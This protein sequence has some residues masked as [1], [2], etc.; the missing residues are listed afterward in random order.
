MPT[1]S[2][3]KPSR[4]T[5]S[6]VPVKIA[7]HRSCPLPRRSCGGRN[8]APLPVM[9][10]GAEGGAE[11]SL[12]ERRRTQDARQRESAPPHFHPLTRPDEAPGHSCGGRN[13]AP[14]PVML[15]GAGGGVRASARNILSGNVRLFRGSL[16]GGALRTGPCI[17]SPLSSNSSPDARHK[18]H[19][20]WLS[21]NL[22]VNQSRHRTVPRPIVESGSPE[23]RVAI[24]FP[25][26]SEGA[27]WTEPGRQAHR[28][29]DDSE[30]QPRC[31]AH[32]GR[33]DRR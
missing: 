16:A 28:G 6:V 8:L 1:H 4:V 5:P 25:R 10:S 23:M 2:V 29:L 14:L 32:R 13:L 33:R 9:L 11:T 20:Y 3:R 19:G 26:T 18:D 7:P 22:L 30:A 21:L 24:R 31:Q 12:G 27:R 17:T 15:S